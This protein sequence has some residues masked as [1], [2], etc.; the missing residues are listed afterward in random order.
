M[1]SMLISV[2]FLLSLGKPVAAV[3]VAS[4]CVH[5]FSPLLIRERELDCWYFYCAGV[6]DITFSNVTVDGTLSLVNDNNYELL[7]L[8][9]T[10]EMYTGTFPANGGTRFVYNN[11]DNTHQV[12]F[13]D[14]E[15]SCEQDLPVP[16]AVGLPP[17]EYLTLSQTGTYD[18]FYSQEGV[19]RWVIPCSGTLSIAES[20]GFSFSTEV[21]FYNSNGSLVLSRFWG[22]AFSTEYTVEGNFVV[23]LTNP[24]NHSSDNFFALA[25]SCNGDRPDLPTLSGA[26]SP[27]TPLPDTLSP[28][29]TCYVATSP[30]EVSFWSEAHNDTS[31]EPTKCWSFQ[32]MGSVHVTFHNVSLE[33]TVSLVNSN[34]Y[35]LM[36]LTDSADYSASYPANGEMMVVYDPSVRSDN[37]TWVKFTV[38][39]ECEGGEHVVPAVGFNTSE[40]LTLPLSGTYERLFSREGLY[41]WI[42]PCVGTLGIA[43]RVGSV[44]SAEV[45]FINSNGSVVRLPHGTFSA[46]YEVAGN[47]II[48]L[49]NLVDRAINNDFF[50]SWNCDGTPFV[51]PS[52][53]SPTAPP[54]ASPTASPT[55]LP[56]GETFAPLSPPAVNALCT[57]DQDCRSGRLDPK[58]TCNAGTC[59]CHT[60]GYAYPPGV[61]LCLLADDVTVPM[62]FAVKYGPEARS[63]WTTSATAEEHFEDT[64]THVLG[65]V[66]DIS[67]IISEDGVLVVGMVRASTAELADALSGKVDLTTALSAEGVSVSHGVTCARTDASYTVEYNGV[68]NA[69]E[70]E[71][72]RILTLLDETYRCEAPPQPDS[73]GGSSNVVLYVGISVG[74]FALVVCA[75]GAYCCRLQQEPQELENPLF[76]IPIGD[77]GGLYP[78]E[79]PVVDDDAEAVEKTSLSSNGGNG[80]NTHDTHTCLQ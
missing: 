12:V 58:A 54:T 8:T 22:G 1:R 28:Q 25:W 19:Y 48:V 17:S 72:D 55:G 42:I 63:A 49:N 24:G 40:Y 36:S 70:C 9:G 20:F 32:C 10:H 18:R 65:T 79:M 27:N 46:E 51:P 26:T 29:S 47:F 78:T 35:N 23:E 37:S 39:W 69:V 3:D 75:V 60:Q 56:P 61:P 74:V 59:V 62:G 66:T 38:E 7:S 5:V 77:E 34:G 44:F 50:M 4:P 71:G 6:V 73:S 64:M 13:T 14:V 15:W 52:T 53:A 57:T 80:Y 45:Q 43:E 31:Q 11:S 16:P 76:E 2:V 67:V 33:G 41:N 68:C 30:M 21:R